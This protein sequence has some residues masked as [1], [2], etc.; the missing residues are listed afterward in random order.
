MSPRRQGKWSA[1]VKAV[2]LFSAYDRLMSSS[3]ERFTN[4]HL[5]ALSDLPD[6]VLPASE[7]SC[8]KQDLRFL[9]EAEEKFDLE[10]GRYIQAGK[11]YW[12]DIVPASRMGEEKTGVIRTGIPGR[13]K[14]ISYEKMNS[15]KNCSYDRFI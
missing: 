6:E 3:P 7:V 10:K 11:G 13:K 4:S 15:L 9:R 14:E 8:C 12:R 2:L 1:A 5:K